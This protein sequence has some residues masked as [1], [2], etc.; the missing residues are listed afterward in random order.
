MD[1]SANKKNKMNEI[2]MADNKK[3][4]LGTCFLSEQQFVLANVLPTAVF[5][6][7]PYQKLLKR[8]MSISCARPNWENIEILQ[9]VFGYTDSGFLYYTCVLKTHFLRLLQRRWK[10]IFRERRLILNDTK[11]MARYLFQRQLG[12]NRPLFAHL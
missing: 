10:R 5:Y 2:T 7:H 4:V 11:R 8:M 1:T 9:F 12:N 3:H 6:R